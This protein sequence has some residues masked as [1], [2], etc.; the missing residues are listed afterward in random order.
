MNTDQSPKS[1][2][3]PAHTH[4]NTCIHAPHISFHDAN[5]THVSTIPG[6]NMHHTQTH[7]QPPVTETSQVLHDAPST[8]L[9][10]RASNLASRIGWVGWKSWKPLPESC[11]NNGV[12]GHRS[13]AS[14]CNPRS[15]IIYT[16]LSTPAVVIPG[17]VPDVISWLTRDS[18]PYYLRAPDMHARFVHWM[19]SRQGWWKEAGFQASNVGVWQ[20]HSEHTSCAFKP[21]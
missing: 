2:T 18:F 9:Q 6:S 8:Q 5:S 3:T 4:V 17:L 21:A 15:T 11:I 16:A 1:C 12:I 14:L 19:R 10:Q 7:L 13:A 20:Q